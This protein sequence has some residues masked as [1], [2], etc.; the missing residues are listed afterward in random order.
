MGSDKTGV[1]KACMERYV[2]DE[3]WVGCRV[4]QG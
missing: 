3:A 1:R 2:R 4:I